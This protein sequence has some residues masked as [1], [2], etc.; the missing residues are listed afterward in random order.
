MVQ[1]AAFALARFGPFEL[2]LK[3]GEL[4]GD[5]HRVRLQ[6][7]PFQVLAFLIE[8]AG[9]LV[10]RQELRDRLWP[11]AVF[12]DFDHGVNKAVTKIRRALGDAAESPRYVETLERR[13]YRFI[14][15]VERTMT[16][17]GGNGAAPAGPAVLPR[18]VWAGR[19]IPL[20]TGPNLIGRDP[21]AVAWIDSA[22]VSRRHAYIHVEAGCASIEDLGSKNGTYHNEQPLKGAAFL[23]DGD[24]IRVGPALLVFRCAA[25]S[26]PTRT[27]AD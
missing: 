11:Q 27:A 4:R 19:T 25:P 9:D 6:E 5:G 8:R 22:Q 12:V 10:T 26:D 18:L 21:G 24:R 20:A 14:A 3:T 16:P 7:Q 2:D 17:A 15:P 13:G 1:P 23:Q